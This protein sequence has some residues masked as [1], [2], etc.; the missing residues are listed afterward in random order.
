MVA[1]VFLHTDGLRRERRGQQ[2]RVWPD[3]LGATVSAF[4]TPAPRS[5]SARTDRL[6]PQIW[7][8]PVAACRRGIAGTQ[9]DQ[10]V[11]N[12][13]CGAQWSHTPDP[14]CPRL[15][16]DSARV[17]ARNGC[18]N[19]GGAGV[20]LRRTARDAFSLK[21]IKLHSPT[22]ARSVLA[23]VDSRKRFARVRGFCARRWRIEVRR[24]SPWQH[25]VNRRFNPPGSKLN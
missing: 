24:A 14:S 15:I 22:S 11:V 3:R 2:T 9:A 25:F 19:S 8:I 13:K 20:R 21:H 7:S 6:L 12:G 18:L 16:V 17:T 4:L 23:G 5:V 1:V 10:P